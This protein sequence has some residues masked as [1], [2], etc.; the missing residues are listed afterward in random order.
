VYEHLEGKPVDKEVKIPV[1]LITKDNVDAFAA[2]KEKAAA[3]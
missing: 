3:K 2:G 1:E